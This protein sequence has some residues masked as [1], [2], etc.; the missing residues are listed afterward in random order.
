M[1]KE[2]EIRRIGCRDKD[3]SAAGLAVPLDDGERR[4]ALISL[5]SS[6][7]RAERAAAGAM[8]DAAEKELQSARLALSELAVKS[9]GSGIVGARYCEEGER[10]RAEDKILT[11][12]DTA[13]L[14]AVFPVR[15]KDALRI[16]K[17]MPALVEID[18]SGGAS[19]GRVDLVYPQADSQS[20]SFMVRVLL[21]NNGDSAEGT[22]PGPGSLKPGM[23]ARVKVTL[24]PPR[25]I[26]VFPDSSIINK[27]NNEGTVFVINGKT[28]SERKVGLG[29]ALGEDRE[30]TSGLK[31]GELAV[32]R[33][34]ADLREGT[35]VSAVY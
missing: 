12:M 18:G 11:L 13:S 4:K 17:G 31:S 14:Y 8:L 6:S 30:I 9:P 27:K 7:L 35:H 20:M 3:L 5:I 24:G 29:L 25:Q 21:L 33:P 15:E 22:E 26:I 32:L 2:L 10:V 28:L 19:E 34:E 1:E 16:E 23:F